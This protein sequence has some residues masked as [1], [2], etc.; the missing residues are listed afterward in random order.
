MDAAPGG[1]ITLR[2]PLPIKPRCQKK[3]RE[4]NRGPKRLRGLRF[5]T[6]S[7]FA[8]SSTAATWPGTLTLCQAPAIT[9]LAS[10]R[11]VARSMPIYLR[12]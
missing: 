10:T 2:R 1:H 6:R 8:A 7:C 5:F 11:K 4:V 12:P 9:P 3:E